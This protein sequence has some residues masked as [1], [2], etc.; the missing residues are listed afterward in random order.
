MILFLFP[1]HLLPK[2]NKNKIK[3]FLISRISNSK[4]NF[5]NSSNCHNNKAILNSLLSIFQR[6]RHQQLHKLKSMV[7]AI[8]IHLDNRQLM[9]MICFSQS[10]RNLQTLSSFHPQFKLGKL[11]KIPSLPG[12]LRI[13][14]SIQTRVS[15]RSSRVQFWS[16]SSAQRRSTPRTSLD[17]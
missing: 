7:E 13:S 5:S 4:N 9:R 8:R 16:I 1:L 15:M 3:F 14:W 10:M 2:L 6:H 11:S 12:Q 17:I